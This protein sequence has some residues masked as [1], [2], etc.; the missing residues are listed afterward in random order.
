MSEADIQAWATETPVNAVREQQRRLAAEFGGTPV[1]TATTPATL[2]P[3]EGMLC[4]IL[5]GVG[6]LGDEERIF[7]VL[8]HLEPIRSVRMLRAVLARLD[9][10]FIPTER[11]CAE[12]ARADLPCLLVTA[13]DDCLLLTPGTG[14]GIE[15]YALGTETRRSAG[16]LDLPAG[17][18]YLLR[19]GKAAADVR[20]PIPYGGLVGSVI[21]GLGRPLARIAGASA[22]INAL[23]LVLSLY[24]LFVYDV[25]IA[26]RAWDT[27][28]FFA[29]GA[30]GVLACELKLRRTRARMIAY[31]A[32][33][34]DG[35]VS[36]RTLASV[37][38][39]P[40]SMT[41]RAPLAAQV[42]RFR[43]F[44]IGRELFAGNLASA[45]FDLPFTLLFT[46]A[47]FVVGGLLG[48]VP[49]ALSLAVAAVAGLFATISVAQVAKVSDSK[50][51]A[52][53]LLFELTDKLPIIRNAAAEGIWLGR[54]AESLAAYQR[55][56]FRNLQLNASLQTLT[57]GLVAL[58]GII[59]LTVG[60]LRV[61]ASTMS[62]GE[63]VAAMI[64]VWR[65]LAPVQV[66]CL[67]IA[68]LRQ[69]LSTV[70]QINEVARMR[71]ER[72]AETPPMLHRHLGG[73]L[74]ASGVYLSH[75]AQ[76]EPQLRGLNLEVKAGEIVAITGPS[77]S[78]KSTLLKVFLGLYPHYMGTVRLGGFDLRQL[79]PTEVRA[80]IGYAPQQ[81]TFFYGSLAA[82]FRF[83]CSGATDAD[84]ME[85]LAAVGLSLPNADLPD[86][87][88]T[89]I[90]GTGA[91]SLSQGVLMRLSLA[92]A[93][94]KRPAMLFLD[95]PG[96][97]L[98][99][100]GDDALIAHLA[101]L[102][103][104]TTVL[105]ATARPSHMRIADRVI[106]MRAGT[107]VMDG[108]PEVVVPRILK[109]IADSA[110]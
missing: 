76:H 104:K 56:R 89:R 47:L 78:G 72:E 87:L 3:F 53:A 85:A 107:V 48:F 69:T 94:V 2:G 4:E 55:S 43:Q 102:R 92:R 88:A 60:A 75:S 58:A 7:E 84:I 19:Y 17:Q 83:A 32:A 62:I 80:G 5:A 44:E 16:N 61:M 25:I 26:T 27:L 66:V 54:Y 63:L 77:G 97:G 41:E 51:K 91:R 33:R 93:L 81:P 23:G 95:D 64:I 74:F 21:K 96:T 10:A 108:K 98:D 8:P 73:H 22:L 40:L 31:V 103:G 20:G 42:S 46:A 68:R 29:A 67:N 65:V 14:E 106:A 6:W 49:V 59:T 110:A 1:P 24:V 35:I 28:A 82:N 34:F 45:L 90:S 109:Q 36:V 39:L 9:V 86:G 30:L 15:V 101:G 50:L 79:D 11:T 99:R 100:A 105:L 57:N 71:A 37:L 70:R 12:L 18:V 52:D 38:N 13:H